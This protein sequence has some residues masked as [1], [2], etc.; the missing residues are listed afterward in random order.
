MV[1]MF[2]TKF[3]LNLIETPLCLLFLIL[4][5][6]KL[7]ITDKIKNIGSDHKSQI[8]N[9][10][11]IFY[12]V[13]FMFNTEQKLSGD[14]QL[15]CPASPSFASKTC[16]LIMISLNR[17]SF[18]LSTNIKFAEETE[19]MI[20][21]RFVFKGFKVQCSDLCKFDSLKSVPKNPENHQ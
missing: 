6:I 5:W 14:R 3:V 20:F 13:L 12:A 15:W 11:K 17:I 16:F 8:T 21:F 18:C 1:Q 4:I 9:N 19:F 10:L 2:W 7:T